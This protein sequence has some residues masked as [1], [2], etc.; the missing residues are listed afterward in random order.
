MCAATHPRCATRRGL[1]GPTSVPRSGDRV[2]CC[3][4][5]NTRNC[6]G[7]CPAARS[8]H[9]HPRSLGNAASLR[10]KAG[11]T[12]FSRKY[13]PGAGRRHM[14]GIAAPSSPAAQQPPA[15]PAPAPSSAPPLLD[16]SILVA[17]ASSWIYGADCAEEITAVQMRRSDN[18]PQDWGVSCH[19]P[20][21]EDLRAADPDLV[22]LDKVAAH[23]GPGRNG[24]RH[25]I[26]VLQLINGK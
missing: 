5:S 12:S 7:P 26:R 3:S 2:G 9:A 18:D 23:F 19:R 14:A 1:A 4:E 21:E 6:V 11:E 20:F 24:A 16:G 22:R 17:R 25:H 10:L 8:P 15:M 13:L